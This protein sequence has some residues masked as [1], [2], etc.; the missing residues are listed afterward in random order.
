M[1]GLIKAASDQLALFPQIGRPS[2][3]QKTR[4]FAVP[5]TPFILFYRVV[6]DKVEILALFHGAQNWKTRI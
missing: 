2:R 6:G 3:R 1:V 5:A 4:E